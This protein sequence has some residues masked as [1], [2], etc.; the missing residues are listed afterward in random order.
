[1]TVAQSSTTRRQAGT[2]TGLAIVEADGGGAPV[3]FVHGGISDHRFWARQLES[4]SDA[5]HR[6]IAYSRRHHWPNPPP[7][8]GETFR[9][10]Q[11]VD[12]LVGVLE[13]TGSFPAHLVGNSMGGTTCLLFA[14]RHPQLVRSL[15][16]AEPNTVTLLLPRPEDERAVPRQLL[17][18]LFRDPAAALAMARFGASTLGPATK[19]AQ[20][21][22]ADALLRTFTD[23]VL[24]GFS[25]TLPDDARAMMRD[26]LRELLF[27]FQAPRLFEPFT[28]E[29]A[30]TIL[31]PTLLVT[32]GRSPPFLRA[33][34]RHLA[35]AMPN[36]KRAHLPTASH[37][38]S[39]DAMGGDA[40]GFDEAALDFLRGVDGG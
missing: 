5:G 37:A 30:R 2:P 35:R 8:A 14:R 1:V 25:A 28:R 27:E 29:D 31:A 19:A 20:A 3:V 34:A 32:G 15:T 22:D 23:G 38:I 13:E 16:L 24:R 4:F 9:L 17:R 33:I 26:N 10:S 40:R 21:G 36:A 7:S 6:A 11:Q 39:N 12:D 18:L